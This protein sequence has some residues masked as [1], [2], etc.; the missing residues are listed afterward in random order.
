MLIN[1]A[2]K[3]I[4]TLNFFKPLFK[5]DVCYTGLPIISSVNINKP[6]YFQQNTQAEF[7]SIRF[8]LNPLMP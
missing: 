3:L 2:K 7:Q 1:V 6:L 8:I 4:K 5:Y